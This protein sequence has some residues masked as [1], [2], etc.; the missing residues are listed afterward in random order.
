MKGQEQP[1]VVPMK[2]VLHSCMRDLHRVAFS[3]SALGA[4]LSAMKSLTLTGTGI[5]S[6]L[7]TDG[8]APSC[9]PREL[10]V[11]TRA[12]SLNYRD[13]AIVRGEY[14]AFARP[15][16]LGSDAVGEVVAVGPQ[17]QRFRVGDRVCPHDT[18]DWVSGPPEARALERRLGGPAPGVFAEVLCIPEH[19]AVAVPPHLTDEEAATLPAAGVTAYQAVFTLG[20]ARPGDTVL[21]Q[22]TGGVSLYALQLAR[23]AGAQVLV[24]SRSADKLARA[25]A[26]GACQVIDSTQTPAWEIEVLRLTAGRGADLVVD[27]AGGSALR[28]SIEATRIGGVVVLLG[29]LDGTSTSLDMP[30]LI[31]RSVTLRA[32]SGRS[33]E[34]FEALVRAIGAAGLRPVIDR[35]FD[36]D[37][38]HAAFAHLA[39]GTQCGKVVMRLPHA[40]TP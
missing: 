5:D 8:P 18:P 9:G 15:L 39:S 34:N 37:E 14:G 30:S 38:A 19:A 26:L 10:L 4:R 2:H 31:R 27:V 40:A 36:F 21:V 16:V 32:S 25:Q 22:G 28:R 29:F 33:R 17:V 13:L 7:L 20:Q 6:L 1:N 11:R 3:K 24:V 23:L 35:V 12:V